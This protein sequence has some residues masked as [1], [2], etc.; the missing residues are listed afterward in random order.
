MPF[1]K[2]KTN[3]S[4]SEEKEINIKSFIGKAIE[5]I[6]GKSE[7][8]ILLNIE[9]KQRM[10]LRGKDEPMIYIEASIYGNSDHYGFD[11]FAKEVSVFLSRE[12]NV[13]LRN[14]YIKFEDVGPWSVGGY[15]ING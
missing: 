13:D 12:L 4:I 9:D 11:R 5:T 10:W 3:I 2:L 1:I 7:K 15:F 14:I 6:P 8:Y